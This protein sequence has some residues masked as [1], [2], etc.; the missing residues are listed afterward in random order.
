MRRGRSRDPR[1]TAFWSRYG[2]SIGFRLLPRF[3]E[4][5]ISRLRR[6]SAGGVVAALGARRSSSGQDCG[7]RRLDLGSEHRTTFLLPN[8]WLS[9][10]R[11]P[12]SHRPRLCCSGRPPSLRPSS[13]PARSL[14]PPP[15][16]CHTGRHLIVAHEYQDGSWELISTRPQQGVCFFE[17]ANRQGAKRVL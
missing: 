15:V 7:A 11:P 10:L 13:S 1:G 9:E 16:R 5:R 2:V 8:S 17:Y 6:V 4:L 14:C 3:S 12:S